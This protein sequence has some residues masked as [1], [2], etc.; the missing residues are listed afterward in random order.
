MLRYSYGSRERLRDGKTCNLECFIKN[1]G[2]GEEG[3]GRKEGR[4]SLAISQPFSWAVNTRSERIVVDWSRRQNRFAWVTKIIYRGT[5]F[6]SYLLDR[7]ALAKSYRSVDHAQEQEQKCVSID[8][9]RNFFSLACARARDNERFIIAQRTLIRCT[10][11]LVVKIFIRNLL[12]REY[13]Y[14]M[15]GPFAT[16]LIA[17]LINDAEL[18][19]RLL[20]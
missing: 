3:R 19:S 13:E 7:N 2:W 9:H 11:L 12:V 14:V 4:K 18:R 15:V 10:F 5:L 8:L 1:G 20:D 17:R 16:G 6:R